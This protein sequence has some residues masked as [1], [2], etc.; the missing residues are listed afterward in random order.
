VTIGGGRPTAATND[1]MKTT[2]NIL[3]TCRSKERLPAALLVF[4]TL[5]T[6]FPTAGVTVFGNG[7]AP[8][9][10]RIIYNQAQRA[11]GTFIPLKQAM[12][13]GEWIE[14]LLEWNSSAFWIC[15]TDVVFFDEVENWFGPWH[16]TEFAGRY[17]PG[18]NC[19][20][21]RATHV[22]RLHPSLMFLNAPRLRVSTRAWPHEPPFFNTVE[23]NLF[24]WQWVPARERALEGARGDQTR[25]LFYDT[26]AGLYHALGG[27]AFNDAQ[28]EAFEHLY[29]GTYLDLIRQHMP[30]EFASAHAEVYKD[31]AKAKGMWAAQQRWYRERKPRESDK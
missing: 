31:P 2:V 17:E 23:R 26:C 8:E 3:V 28:N 5:R 15:D 10:E 13:H 16:D 25:L 30:P 1:E 29:A 19:D 18:F 24:R 22:A 9:F 14:Q 6:G 27:T 4:E 21:T 7:L 20:W 12:A 11:A